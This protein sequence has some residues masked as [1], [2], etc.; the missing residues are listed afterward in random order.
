MRRDARCH[1]AKIG[2]SVS[3]IVKGVEMDL[4]EVVGVDEVCYASCSMF[5][6]TDLS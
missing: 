5:D 6:L 2:K 3:K 1:C 4:R